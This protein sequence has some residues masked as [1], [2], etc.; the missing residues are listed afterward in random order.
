MAILEV[1][2]KYPRFAEHFKKTMDGISERYENEITEETI[3][4]QGQEV[5]FRLEKEEEDQFYLKITMHFAENIKF[6]ISIHSNGMEEYFDLEL[7][8]K[9][10]QNIVDIFE[11]RCG[12]DAKLSKLLRYKG[13]E[14]TGKMKSLRNIPVGIYDI[15]HIRETHTLRL[16][17]DE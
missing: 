15:Y 7:S 16:D 14:F 17:I 12:R 11:K 8:V 5:T 13:R 6:L 2:Q 9:G 4:V 10:V 3:T 1:L